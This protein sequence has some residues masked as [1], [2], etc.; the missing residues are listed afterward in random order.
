MCAHLRL[1]Y[2]HIPQHKSEGCALS[3]AV[4][5]FS[6]ALYEDGDVHPEVVTGSRTPVDQTEDFK[7]RAASAGSTSGERLCAPNEAPLSDHACL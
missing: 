5:N 4:T 1:L 2:T 6:S 3:Q 7:L